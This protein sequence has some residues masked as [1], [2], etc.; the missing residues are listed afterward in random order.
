MA[1]LMNFNEVV[2]SA[3]ENDETMFMEFQAMLNEATANMGEV[4]GLTKKE[5][6]DKIAE[7]FC[8]AIG[9]KSARYL[10]SA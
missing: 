1:K 2:R 6:N 9:C 7:K 5:V 10:R 4:E 8:A 3:F